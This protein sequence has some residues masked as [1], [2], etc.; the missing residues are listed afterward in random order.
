GA[1]V[2]GPPPVKSPSLTDYPA[3]D[4]QVKRLADEL[5]GALDDSAKVA[6]HTCGKG[7]VIWGTDFSGTQAAQEQMS[8]FPTA[9]WIWYKE[10]NPAE[11]AP[12]GKR[13]FRRV[14]NLEP[15]RS[16]T[17][18]PFSLTADNAFELWV[19]GRRAGAGDNF[20][21]LYSLNVSRL[22]KPGT[23]LLCVAAENTSDTPNPAG[24]VGALT[25]RFQDGGS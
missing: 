15:N 1:T 17:S 25:I 13:Y 14:L 18:G 3:C 2:V 11:S 16:I 9:K 12:P 10:G 5:W 7:R 4:A 23:N 20:Q 22:L 19:N 6:E 8:P 24:L 21:K